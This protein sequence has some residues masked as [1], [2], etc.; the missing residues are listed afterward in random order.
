MVTKNKSFTFPDR[1]TPPP[2][3]RSIWKHVGTQ[4]ISAQNKELAVDHN[5]HPWMTGM[6]NKCTLSSGKSDNFTSI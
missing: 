4:K 3:S 2:G 1:L 5:M 6:H